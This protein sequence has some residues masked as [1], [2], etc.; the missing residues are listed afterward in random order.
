MQERL[1]I[2]IF[3]FFLFEEC[4]SQNYLPKDT[5]YGNVKNIKEK[6]YFLTEIENPQL[7]Y[8]DDY[9]HSGFMGPEATISRF[10][11]TWYTS[12]LCYYINYDRTFD[13]NGNIVQDLWFGKK[14]NFKN[15]YKKIYNDNKKIVKE[16]DSTNYSIYTTNYYY[17]D[18]G[19][20]N[21]IRQDSKNGFFRH[22]Y[23]KF[24]ENQLK[25]LKEF[26]ENGTIDE[27]KYFYNTQ[28]KLNYR[29]YKNPNSWKNEGERTWSYGVQDSILTVYKDIINYYDEKNRLIKSENYDLYEDDEEHKKPLLTNQIINKY[30]DDNLIFNKRKYRTG[31]ESFN[32]YKYNKNKQISERYCCNEDITKA[33]I[34]EK[35]KYKKEK[36]SNLTYIEEGKKYEISF[37][38]KYDSKNNWIEIVKNVDGK[39]LFKWVRKIEYF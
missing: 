32:Y 28:G 20:L 11:D 4:T 23:K 1:L 7:L 13:Q 26:D 24:D 6:V 10:K 21:I 33:M 36:I 31:M 22:T 8:Y 37:K 25:I 3:S 34:V 2:L 17:S 27:Y 19:D 12:N 29:I 9:G 5:I 30:E 16:V 14:D 39:D 38:Y 15:S 35:Y 18:Y